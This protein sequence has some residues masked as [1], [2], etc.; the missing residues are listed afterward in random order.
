MTQ[1]EK[2]EYVEGAVNEIK[3]RLANI[4]E[5]KFKECDRLEISTKDYC[6][7][8]SFEMMRLACLLAA[9][10]GVK[11]EGLMDVVGRLYD[12]AVR[13]REKVEETGELAN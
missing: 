2:D 7:D 3:H 4:L 11:K 1:E 8:I 10:H 5:E 13:T 9:A 6:A 12:N